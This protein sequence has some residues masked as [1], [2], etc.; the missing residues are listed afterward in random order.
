MAKTRAIL[1]LHRDNFPAKV[2]GPARMLRRVTL[3]NYNRRAVSS[4]KSLC[5]REMFG[6]IFV[7]GQKITINMNKPLLLILIFAL[8]FSSCEKSVIRDD[9]TPKNYDIPKDYPTTY[10]KLSQDSLV[11]MQTAYVLKNKY[12]VSSLN[13]F[14]FCGKGDVPSLSPP[15]SNKITRDEAV[16]KVKLFC[17]QNP[18][19]TGVKNPD[20]LKLDASASSTNFNGTSTWALVFSSQIYDTSEVIDT[21]FF[22]RLKSAEVVS[23]IGNWYPNVYIPKEFNISQEEA[24]KLVINKVF[25]RYTFGGIKYDVTISSEHLTNSV[26]RLS[27]FP[28][29]TDDKI[30]LR[31]TW[32]IWIQSVSYIIYV[33][34]MTGD[35]V[36]Q[37]STSIS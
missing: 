11:K 29:I 14:G 26:V 20:D 6:T 8:L 1:S 21:R 13:Y 4:Y 23:C 32:Q 27:I 7:Y 12:L 33:D 16:A 9:D 24:K 15:F 3:T 22:F 17:S 25:S 37:A 18:V 5:S 2:P 31:V 30:E 35:I 34:V 28:V 19:E 36:G 10:S